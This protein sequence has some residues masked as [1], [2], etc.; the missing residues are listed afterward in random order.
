MIEKGNP[1]ALVD[2]TI[3]S[4][5]TTIFKDAS[6]QIRPHGVFGPKFVAIDPG[7]APG[8]RFRDG[9]A[10]ALAST[11][12]SVDFEEVL[13]SLDS[14]TRQSLQTVLYELGTA[15][16]APGADF[17]TTL[18][19]VNVVEAQLTPVLQVVDNRAY[20][21]GRLFESNAVVTETYADSSLD[22]IIHK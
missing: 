16:Q 21:T 9:D 7:T 5:K 14:N 18:D 3:D 15:S 1:G 13:N 2:M 10:I 22:Q 4:K 12:V 11:R 19:Q 20:N 17:G 8:G 6:L